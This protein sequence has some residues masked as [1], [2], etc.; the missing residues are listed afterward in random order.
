[1][2]KQT[3]R[4]SVVMQRRETKGR[5]HS[6]VWEPIGVVP[7]L[8]EG[9]APRCIVAQPDDEQWLFPGLEL[10]LRKSDADCYYLNITTG[11]PSVFVLWREAGGRGVPTFLTASYSEASC[12]LDAGEQVDRVPMPPDIY[13][14]VGDFV[15]QNYR[16]E[17]KARLRPAS[18]RKPKDRVSG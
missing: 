5:W 6:E 18:F 12:W 9:G 8:A 14:W 11:R 15:E 4:V 1:M 3:K 7:D 16:P 17:P 10:C 2:P 13:A